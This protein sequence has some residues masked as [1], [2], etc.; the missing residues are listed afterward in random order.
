[1]I[2][3]IIIPMHNNHEFTL[4]CLRSIQEHTRDY[5]VIVVDNGSTPP[6]SLTD[7]ARESNDEWIKILRNDDNRGYGIAHNQGL[8]ASK[9]ELIASMNNDTIMTPGWLE[10]LIWHLENGLDLVGPRTNAAA[11]AQWLKVNYT[12]VKGIL[13]SLDRKE[14]DVFAQGLHLHNLHKH[15]LSYLILPFCMLSRRKLLEKIGGFDECY[16]MGLFEDND[17]CMKAIEAGFKLGIADDVFI[18]HW[19]GVTLKSTGVDVQAL[20][21]RNQKIFQTKWPITKQAELKIKVSG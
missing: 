7:T 6:F 4:A 9:G 14:L 21:N 13:G 5:E 1:M 19:G 15:H 18:H 3:S 20:F 11:N 12:H 10:Y 2:T 8:K 16:G 17:F